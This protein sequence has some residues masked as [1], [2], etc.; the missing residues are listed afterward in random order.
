MASPPPAPVEV[1]GYGSN[2]PTDL[3]DHRK[4]PPRTSKPSSDEVKA[5]PPLP[6]PSSSLASSAPP[7]AAISAVRFSQRV[8]EDGPQLSSDDGATTEG[9]T[10]A[11]ADGSASRRRPAEADDDA[12]LDLD[13][14]DAVAEWSGSETTDSPRSLTF[15]DAAALHATTATPPTS[16]P[17]PPSTS[18][19]AVVMSVVSLSIACLSLSAVGPMFLFLEK[20]RAVPAI[21]AA[22]WRCQ[23]MLLFISVPTAVECW[24]M[25]P[26]EKVWSHLH[27]PPSPTAASAAPEPL[28][29]ASR[30]A[31]ASPAHRKGV[32]SM[33]EMQDVDRIA[34]FLDG[35]EAEE[36]E[37]TDDGDSEP[38][39]HALTD[40]TED[41]AGG[42]GG[43]MKKKGKRVRVAITTVVTQSKM[44]L[45]H[46]SWYVLAVGLTWAG[47]LALWVWA[48]CYTSTARASLFSSTYP[49]ILLGWMR[50]KGVQ[51]SVMETVGV[52]IALVGIVTS[53]VVGYFTAT[54]RILSEP[55]PAEDVAAA[56]AAD[57][58]ESCQV[59]AGSSSQLIG[60]LMCI[61]ASFL[62]AM[63][64]V[65]AS[66]ARRVLRL[67]SYTL[68]TTA[69]VTVSLCVLTTV[70]E[71]TPVSLSPHGLF[72]WLVDPHMFLIISLFGF[73]VGCIGVLGQ[74]FAVRYTSPVIFSVVQLLDPGLTAFMSW[75][76]GL[77]RWPSISTGLGVGMV[78]AGIAFVVLGENGRKKRQQ[79]AS[80]VHTYE[81]IQPDDSQHA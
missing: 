23:A 74:N 72:G 26:D 79:D 27:V 61:L 2:L 28:A 63:N 43:M 11:D 54:E 13:M 9:D 51:V 66:R 15:D 4:K 59:V 56:P 45:V 3:K 80:D 18:P 73:V 55:A 69:I 50:W 64:I 20:E 53:E 24:H 35:E 8:T 22:A 52:F 48:L 76:A 70:A 62:N 65:W 32:P 34:T 71:A 41:G 6:P 21:L 17:P 1:N 38:R 36:E 58:W 47:S 68:C 60:D 46:V 57:S 81:A 37:K 75:L 7:P 67:F 19:Y 40:L 49:L 30:V 44:R 39:L 25:T 14:I 33:I 77:E 5:P 12:D 31:S 78:G 42:G 29:T 10:D 16:P